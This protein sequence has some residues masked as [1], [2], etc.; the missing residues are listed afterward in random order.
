MQLGGG[1]MDVPVRAKDGDFWIV[2]ATLA[3]G[4]EEEQQGAAA[5]TPASQRLDQP[6]TT[7]RDLGAGDA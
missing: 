6:G 2:L 1:K 7:R 5:A 3:L 4:F